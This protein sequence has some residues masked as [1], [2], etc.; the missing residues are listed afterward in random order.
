MT[1][2]TGALLK[3]MVTMYTQDII[4]LERKN[5]KLENK[6]NRMKSGSKK[7]FGNLRS[8]KEDLECKLEDTERNAKNLE[9]ENF[10]LKLGISH[11]DEIINHIFDNTKD[12]YIKN[13]LQKAGIPNDF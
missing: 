7:A 12:E 8:E 2:E 4:E 3:E 10:S 9:K 5:I 1:T 11:R 6:I 13:Y